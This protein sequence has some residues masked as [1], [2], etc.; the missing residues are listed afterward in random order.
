MKRLR[1]NQ[2]R[3]FLKWKRQKIKTNLWE[4]KNDYKREASSNQYPHKKV[5]KKS[6]INNLS[7]HFK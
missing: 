1:R 4:Q 2:E 3:K 5:R 6:Q 7:M